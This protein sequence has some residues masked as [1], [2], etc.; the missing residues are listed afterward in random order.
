MCFVVTCPIGL[1]IKFTKPWPKIESS[2]KL[3]CSQLNFNKKTTVSYKF[4]ILDCNIDLYGPHICICH[5]W[6][7]WLCGKRN[8]NLCH[9]FLCA[10]RVGFLMVPFCCRNVVV[11]NGRRAPTFCRRRLQSVSRRCI[12]VYIYIVVVSGFFCLS[13]ESHSDNE[14][15]RN[16]PSC[17][18][19]RAAHP[20]CTSAAAAAGWA[21]MKIRARAAR[22]ENF[23]SLTPPFTRYSAVIWRP[24][25]SESDLTLPPL[26]APGAILSWRIYFV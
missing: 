9:H 22:R 10:R 4:L 23:I 5:P 1:I 2:T 11:H 13:I 18:Q 17:T 26:L 19:Q 8:R 21:M 6:A 14:W 25:A 3:I 24:R 20:I 16:R 12:C 15:R 7:Y